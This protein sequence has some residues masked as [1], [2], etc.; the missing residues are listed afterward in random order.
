MVKF[1]KN[2]QGKNPRYFILNFTGTKPEANLIKKMLDKAFKSELTDFAIWIGEHVLG[3]MGRITDIDIESYLAT[4]QGEE[5]EY[6][7]CSIPNRAK[8][9]IT[10]KLHCLTCHKDIEVWQPKLPEA[11]K[12]NTCQYQNC[13]KKQY[14]IGLCKFH[15]STYGKR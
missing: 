5:K 7:K 8:S 9:M 6:C 11:G 2:N 4:L 13:D 3:D 12:D 14:K 10:G 1:G 15:Y